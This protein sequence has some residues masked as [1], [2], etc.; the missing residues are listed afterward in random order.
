[1]METT[2][3]LSVYFSFALFHAASVDGS[4]HYAVKLQGSMRRALRALS[5]A[6]LVQAIVLWSLLHTVGTA[7]LVC[8]V[9]MSAFGCLIIVLTPLFPRTMWRLCLF[10]PLA[11][12]TCALAGAL[13]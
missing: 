5:L 13:L 2:S 4:K 7:L 3:F 1:M 9:S 8:L 10:C 11:I 6:S 12:V